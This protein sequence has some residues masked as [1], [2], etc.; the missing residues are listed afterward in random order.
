MIQWLATHRGRCAGVYRSIGINVERGYCFPGQTGA[1]CGKAEIVRAAVRT[2]GVRL[3][4]KL[5]AAAVVKRESGCGGRQGASGVLYQRGIAGR[6]VEVVMLPSTVSVCNV[7]V[8]SVLLMV[9][10]TV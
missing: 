9:V 3:N 5:T 4:Q 1:A 6:E 2:G 10:S 7:P 8:G